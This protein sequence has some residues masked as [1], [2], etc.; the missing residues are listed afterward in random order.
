MRIAN[1]THAT[2]VALEALVGLASLQSKDGDREHALELVLTVLNHSA[3]VQETRN[4][5]AHLN[6]GLEAQ[7]TS[8]QVEAAQSRGQAKSLEA[9]V[10]EALKAAEGT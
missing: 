8:R 5:A 10:D 9:V 4:R 3:S 7:L 2:P 1:E 6:S